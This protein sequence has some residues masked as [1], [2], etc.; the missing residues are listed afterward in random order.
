VQPSSGSTSL[1][2]VSSRSE[3]WPSRPAAPRPQVYRSPDRVTC[4]RMVRH[5]GFSPID[6]Q[7][8]ETAVASAA[9]RGEVLRATAHGPHLGVG[10]AR[11][12]HHKI[13]AGATHLP[14]FAAIVKIHGSRTQCTGHAGPLRP[15][16]Q[17]GPPSACAL[18]GPKTTAF[19]VKRPARTYK[20]PIQT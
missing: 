1:G 18:P 19:H 20:S 4:H 13:Y 11:V 17:P 5:E 6:S 15:S 9:H 7:P 16:P 2:K 3:P 8:V 14:G 12:I 10:R